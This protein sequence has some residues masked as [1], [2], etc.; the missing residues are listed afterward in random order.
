MTLLQAHKDLIKYADLIAS[1]VVEQIDPR[2][3]FISQRR[4][5]AD[6][7]A[8]LIKRGEES[9]MLKP[10]RNGKAKNSPILYSRKQILA[11]IEA[12]GIMRNEAVA[13]INNLK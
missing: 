1:A 3:N 9:G 6:Y 2:R 7:G 12:E 4:A 13:I 8:D 10:I 5:Y 11:Q